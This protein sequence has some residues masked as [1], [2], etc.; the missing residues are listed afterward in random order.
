MVLCWVDRGGTPRLSGLAGRRLRRNLI[1]KGLDV[2]LELQ[3][4]KHSGRILLTPADWRTFPHL[5]RRREVARYHKRGY[6]YHIT[7]YCRPLSKYGKRALRRI[8][9]WLQGHVWQG[10]V[11]VSHV[12]MPGHVAKLSPGGL[13]SPVEGD[14]IFLRGQYGYHPDPFLTVS[15]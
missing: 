9:S 2:Y 14:M 12:S 15:M 7:L 10:V 3:E 13:F 4:G 6:R 5:C 8:R 11:R 1:K